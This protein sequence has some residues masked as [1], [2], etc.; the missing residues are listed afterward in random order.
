MEYKIE[1]KLEGVAIGREI[2]ELERERWRYQKLLED[3]ERGL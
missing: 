2:A 1:A 3:L